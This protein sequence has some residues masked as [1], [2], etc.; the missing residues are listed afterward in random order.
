[1][2]KIIVISGPPGAGKSTLAI[3]LSEELTLPILAKDGLKDEV[4]RNIKYKGS[5]AN[6]NKGE[7]RSLN[8]LY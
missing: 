6:F 7:H 2:A 8:C 4:D 5:V 3:S 1:M